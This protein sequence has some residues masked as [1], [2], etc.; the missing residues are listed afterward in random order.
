M[1][2][3]LFRPYWRL[4]L[5]RTKKCSPNTDNN[6]CLFVLLFFLEI[7][8]LY[9]VSNFLWNVLL[10]RDSSTKQEFHLKAMGTQ[11]WTSWLK[12]SLHCVSPRNRLS[13]PPGSCGSHRYRRRGCCLSWSGPSPLIFGAF[14]YTTPGSSRRAY[15]NWPADYS[16][17]SFWILQKERPGSVCLSFELYEGLFW[18]CLG[19]FFQKRSI[20]WTF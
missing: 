18:W 5:A 13:C 3:D 19:T 6:W 12:P 4:R 7:A 16:A 8:L 10:Y 2:F 11:Q 1:D 9:S 17:L 15:I 20:S 14:A